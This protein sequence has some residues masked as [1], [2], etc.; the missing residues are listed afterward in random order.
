MVY[1]AGLCLCT[2]FAVCNAL[3]FVYGCGLLV[4]LILG[5]G[6]VV[7]LYVGG[8]FVILVVIIIRG[9]CWRIALGASP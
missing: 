7:C 6:L 2:F 1:T 5:F 9:F 8:G 3:L 4:T